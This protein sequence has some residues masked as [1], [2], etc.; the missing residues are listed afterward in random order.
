MAPK[1]LRKDEGG[2]RVKS[3]A[4]LGAQA[5]DF[6]MLNKP[7]PLPF[8]LSKEALARQQ[9][10]KQPNEVDATAPP[11]VAMKKL[12]T[13]ANTLKDEIAALKWL[14][15]RKEQE[16]NRI[17]E[18]LKKK[19]ASWL[20]VKRHAELA[21][22]DNGF[23]KVKSVV[24]PNNSSSSIDTSHR[25]PSPPPPIQIARPTS[26]RPLI[27][28]VNSTTGQQG[29]RKVLVPV[30]QSLSTATLQ[31]L[32]SQGLL[33]SGGMTPDGKRI[34]VVKK[35][36]G[37][38]PGQ[39]GQLRFISSNGQLLTGT[40]ASPTVVMSSSMG[41]PK[42]VASSN[43]AKV[44]FSNT[45]ATGGV[46]KKATLCQECKVKP[47]KF[48]CSGCSKIWYCSKECQEKNWDIHENEC[49]KPSTSSAVIKQ[50]IID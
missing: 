32:S 16:W 8:N 6:F 11:E 46:V 40:S 29:P 49:G 12:E 33:K 34:I 26:S 19:E 35:V 37:S 15:K 24:Q 3:A 27:S 13:E 23:Q 10:Q 44:V 18:L 45:G 38:I 9:S 47:P 14:A 50:E 42:T 22:T 39:P 31:S 41:A 5:P 48:E 28:T 43:T 21:M 36:A 1:T 2:L 7:L 17:I 20:K 30:S 25:M 4:N